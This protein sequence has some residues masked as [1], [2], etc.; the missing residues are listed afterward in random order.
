MK[1]LQNKLLGAEKLGI[2]VK[3]NLDMDKFPDKVLFP[4]KLADARKKLAKL[5]PKK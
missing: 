1:V 3:V 4:K 5:S 2:V